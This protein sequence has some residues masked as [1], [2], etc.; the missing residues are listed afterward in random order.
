MASES[1]VQ[2]LQ[3]LPQRQ[4]SSCIFRC[5]GPVL[6]SLGLLFEHFR[7]GSCNSLRTPLGVP[8]FFPLSGSIQVH[9]FLICALP[10]SSVGTSPCNLVGFSSQRPLQNLRGHLG[11][12]PWLSQ[13][14]VV[15]RLSFSPYGTDRLGSSMAPLSYLLNMVSQR[16][17]RTETLP[18]HGG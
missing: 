18:G 3:L 15:C 10:S 5:T 2:A 12:S 13:R 8:L 1:Q 16:A 7:A 4:Q 11:A 6:F 17:A 14:L 9:L